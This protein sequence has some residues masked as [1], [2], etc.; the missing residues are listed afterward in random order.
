LFLDLLLDTMGNI[1]I[2]D[3]AAILFCPRFLRIITLVFPVIL[4]CIAL[5]LTDAGRQGVEEWVGLPEETS[6]TEWP[7]NFRYIR[8]IVV[9]PEKLLPSSSAFPSLWNESTPS[10]LLADDAFFFPTSRYSAPLFL[11]AVESAAIRRNK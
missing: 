5:L 7:S 1:E 2:V 10:E 8:L 9:R 3:L 4:D 11:P 6:D